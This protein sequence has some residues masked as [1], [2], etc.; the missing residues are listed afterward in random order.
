MGIGHQL[1]EDPEDAALVH[2][3][4][5]LDGL[6][7]LMRVTLPSIYLKRQILGSGGGVGRV[8]HRIGIM[9][10]KLREDAGCW[11]LAPMPI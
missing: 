5:G 7:D 3:L 8:S 11:R 4:S 2:N 6:Q 9:Q 10:F 1:A